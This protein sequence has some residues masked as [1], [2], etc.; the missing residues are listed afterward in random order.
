MQD[1]LNYTFSGKLKTISLVMMAIGVVT[2][3][4]SFATHYEQTWSN[5][6]HSNFY[7]MAIA[8]GGL[9]FYAVQYA[10]SVSWS[11]SVIRIPQAMSQY[12]WFPGVIM[13][14]IFLFARHHIWH[15]TNEDIVEKLL[16]NGQKNPEFDSIIAGKSGFLNIPFFLI[17]MVLYGKINTTW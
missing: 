8:L 16:P 3:G 17:R 15:W 5:I 13:L 6:M 1:H 7:F 9:F 11:V 2:V 12:L 4:I 10:A 14:L